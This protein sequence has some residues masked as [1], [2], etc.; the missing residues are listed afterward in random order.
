[1]KRSVFGGLLVI[2]FLVFFQAVALHAQ[3]LATLNVDVTDPSGAGIPRAQITLKNIAT[4]VTRNQASDA[5]GLAV[6]PGLT[7][8]KYELAVEANE[9]SA[10]RTTI[11]LTVGQ[12]AYLPVILGVTSRKEQVEVRETAEG[13]DTQKTEVSQVIERQKIADLPIAGRDFIDF[14]LLTPNANVGRST[15]VGAQSPFQETVLELSF[16]GLRET[17]STFFGLDGMDYTTSVSGVQRASPSLDWVLEFRVADSPLTVDNG[18]NLGSVVNTVTKS[19]S[20]DIHGSVYEF[21]RNNELDANNLLSAPGFNTLRFNQFG[22]NLGG[23][24]QHD[25]L[26]YFLGYEGQRRAESPLYS[27]F[28]L[29]CIDTTG[30]LGPGTPSI[31]QVKES[32]GLQPENLG[33]ILQIQDYDKFFGKLTNVISN[34][35]TLNLGYLFTDERNQ[36]IPGAAP[37]QGLPSFYRNNPLRDQTVYGN[38]LHLFGTQWTSETI[39]NYAR[40]TFHLDPVGEGFEPALLVADL[41]DSGGIQGGVHYYREQHFQATENVTYVRGKHSFKFGGNLEPISI[42]A[43]TTFFTPG[44]GIF[45]PQSFFGA[46]PFNSPPF[47]PGTPVEFLF[48]QP[49][50]YFGQQIPPRTLPFSTGLFAGPAA[51]E[52]EDST[53]L[54]F[55]HYL[56]GLYAQDQWKPASKLTLTLGLR[57]DIDFF[58]SASDIRLNGKMHP[59]NYGNVQPRAGLAYSFRQG[60]GVVRAGFGLFTGP[61][62]YSDIMVS[63]QG[64]S[65]FTYM[66]QPLLPEFAN[67][68]N[69]LVGLGPSGIVGVDG[70]FLASQAFSTFTHTGAY[71]APSTLLQFP[72]GYAQR[73]FPNAYAEDASLE[74][75]NEVAKDLFVSVGYQFV[76]ALKLPLYLSINATPSGT[77][78][79]GVQMFTPADPNFGFSLFATPTGYSI[80]HSGTVAVRKPFAHHYSILANYTFSKSIDLATDVQ[81]TDSPMNFLQPNLDRA[82]GNNDVRHRFVLTMLAES[83]NTW[84]PALRNFKLS[85]LNTLQ[86]PRYY[87]ILAGFD[88]NGDGFPFADRVGTIG[89]NTFRGDAS[90]TT[91]VR[92]QKVFSLGERFKAEV[93]AEVFNLFNRA[94]VN[95]IDTV[96]GAA[97]FVGPVP[98]RFGDGVTSPANPTFGSPSYAAP[99]RQVQLALR[100]NF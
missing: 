55:L 7:P 5:A 37:G 34:N 64:A 86:S 20:N 6:M 32:L 81:L 93:S 82:L 4:G 11:T 74:V 51:S 12:T 85:V 16:A 19:G 48:L 75:E 25:K 53:N 77:L 56:T 13:I 68:S 22:G 94:N 36:H 62:D 52:F 18:S 30:C 47:G 79:D 40:R 49:R 23:A 26:F 33:S 90:Y 17:H 70:P 66:N 38:L 67:P 54:N 98:Q 91:D 65:A 1:V 10:S 69:S 44:A 78:P 45:S 83:P 21:F 63:W 97:D 95:A 88:V 15:A 42:A 76:H 59:T 89:R 2:S 9:F 43:Q 71:P 60:K 72:L 46:A 8:G 50:S 100:L 87:S 84:T 24:I 58:P 41:F 96:Y 80:Y 99:A 61:F 3:Q 29:H 35:T 28:I 14:V 31:N 73:K 57:Y 27:S 39:L 92:L